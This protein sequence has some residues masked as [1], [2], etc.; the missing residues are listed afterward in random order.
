M[1]LKQF[2][3]F[4]V[5][6]IFLLF[7]ALCIYLT[8]YYQDPQHEAWL[9]GIKECREKCRPHA[10]SQFAEED[11]ICYCDMTKEIR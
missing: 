3:N 5:F 4:L 6:K 2:K 1:I 9:K 8:Y 10:M 11:L 7:I